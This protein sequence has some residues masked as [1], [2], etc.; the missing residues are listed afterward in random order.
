MGVAS[1]W[2]R[3]LPFATPIGS[4]DVGPT[5]GVIRPNHTRLT[6]GA[7]EIDALI[8]DAAHW[9]VGIAE[10]GQSAMPAVVAS[11]TGGNDTEFSIQYDSTRSR[12]SLPKG[13]KRLAVTGHGL[14]SDLENFDWTVDVDGEQGRH[15]SL[16]EQD[17]EI[18]YDAS[19]GF[20]MAGPRGS[21][22]RYAIDA[23]RRKKGA[24]YDFKPD[25]VRQGVGVEMKSKAGAFKAS[26][27]QPDGRGHPEFNIQYRGKAEARPG[28]PETTLQATI[29]DG[30]PVLLGSVGVSSRQ[31]LQG[32]ID[33]GL[34]DG[35]PTVVGRGDILLKREVAPGVTVAAGTGALAV[36]VTPKDANLQ[37]AALKPVSLAAGVDL[38]KML[39]DYAGSGSVLQVQTGYRVGARKPEGASVALRL[40]TKD[41]AA[42]SGE[43]VAAADVDASGQ[44]MGKVDVRATS[45][46]VNV[47]YQAESTGPNQ[48][49]EVLYRPPKT[50]RESML[51]AARSAF[52]VQIP[53]EGLKQA[54]A[55]GR[56]IQRDGGKPRLQLG[57]QY[58]LGGDKNG[59]EGENLLYD[60]G[61]DMLQPGGASFEDPHSFVRNRK[62]DLDSQIS[63]P[64]DG[65][66]K[67]WLQS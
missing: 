41:N 30:K 14:D 23:K 35:A 17:G 39:P 51:D 42:V 4:M 25:W 28:Q 31:G 46:N 44:L 49:A 21:N 2:Q 9:K 63:S 43:L 62:H 6:L 50:A 38:G 34:K 65:L 19:M 40:S 48:F 24:K 10:K 67:R 47:R 26:V 56:A 58:E 59:V 37:R 13:V 12:L 60:T 16:T 55:F 52:G 29:A 7:F 53:G 1:M 57:V 18:V 54:A 15:L 20:E 61:G 33:F 36:A 32:A 22:V 3:T 45:G 5:L 64:G 11:N 27:L 8:Q 66:G